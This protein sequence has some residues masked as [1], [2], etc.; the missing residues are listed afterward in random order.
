MKLLALLLQFVLMVVA[1]IFGKKDER[2][3]AEEHLAEDPSGD[4]RREAEAKA[5]VKFPKE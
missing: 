4:A 1:R 5:D 2:K 3:T